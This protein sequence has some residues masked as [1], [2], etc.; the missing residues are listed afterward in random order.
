[1]SFAFIDIRLNTAY[2]SIHDCTKTLKI[3]AKCRI[4]TALY[5]RH[6]FGEMENTKKTV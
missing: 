4:P 1:M 2:N 3:D 6:N 5:K